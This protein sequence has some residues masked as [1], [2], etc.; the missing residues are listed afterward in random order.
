MKTIADLRAESDFG[1]YGDDDIDD[2]FI[3]PIGQNRDSDI[4]TESNFAMAVEALEKAEGEGGDDFR[5]ISCNHWACG[6]V[7]YIILRP[8]SKC[9]EVME[10]IESRLEDYPVLN[11]EDFSEREYNDFVDSWECYG[12]R[13]FVKELVKMIDDQPDAVDFLEGLGGDVMMEFYRE[14]TNI[15]YEHDSGGCI[16]FI[17]RAI[18]SIFR[19]DLAAFIEEHGGPRVPEFEMPDL[20][21]F[22]HETCPKC[23]AASEPLEGIRDQH[24]RHCKACGHK[25][26]EFVKAGAVR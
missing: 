9:V 2:W 4:L 23:D 11:D 24:D 1:W 12:C 20:E 18:G 16:L 25:W 13:D 17:D 10:D 22:P 14:N 19:S 15:E 7:E 3:A 26:W 5:V 6:W 21:Y 8:G